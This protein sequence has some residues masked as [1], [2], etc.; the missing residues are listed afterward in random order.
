[1]EATLQT[2]D[3]LIKKIKSKQLRD[4]NFNSQH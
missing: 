1:M 2:I 4:F 3:N